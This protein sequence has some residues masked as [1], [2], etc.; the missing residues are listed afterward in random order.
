MP[1]L[2]PKFTHLSAKSPATLLTAGI[3]SKA[4][5]SF[6][7]ADSSLLSVFGLTL[8]SCGIAYIVQTVFFSWLGEMVK[9]R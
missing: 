2:S 4:G 8:G 9:E 1:L 5:P 6:S 7:G 3:P